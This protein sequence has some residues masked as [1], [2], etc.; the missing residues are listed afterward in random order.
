M[1]RREFVTLKEFDVTI[2]TSWETNHGISGHLFEMIEYFYHLKFHK[3]KSVCIFISNGITPEQFRIA[4]LKYD[5]SY[6][7]YSIILNNTFF[8]NKPKVLI[9]NDILFVDG[10]LRNGSSEIFCKRKIVF[11]C[12]PNEDLSI[13]DIV[14]Q[15]F[16][17][18]QELE[19]SKN[20]KKKILFDKFK[21]IE[22]FN[23]A[24]M[25]YSTSNAKML[26][27]ENIQNII[28]KY[29]ENKYIILSNKKFDVPDN[30]ELLMVPIEN[31][32]EKFSTY[33]YTEL[34][35]SSIIDCSPR[36]I[37]ECKHYNKKVIYE[38]SD[39]NKGLEVRIKDLED[40][41]KITLDETDEITEIANI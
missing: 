21:K 3:K 18:Y 30:V 36:F 13:A 6:D 19:N 33:I 16:D 10:T 8:N 28:N 1:R 35:P 29:G 25:M 31:L 15:D 37:A 32:W 38:I 41:S 24:F 11:R 7:E 20:Y 2:T 26:S 17:V 23:N 39:I 40:I 5:F 14:L 9:A 34:L 4:L 22:N 27:K 12:A